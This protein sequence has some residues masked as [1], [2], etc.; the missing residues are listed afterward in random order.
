ML[1][2][3]RVELERRQVDWRTPEGYKELQRLLRFINLRV[4]RGAAKSSLGTHAGL[5][6]HG[7]RNPNETIA[8]MSVNDDGASAFCRQIRETME[9]DLYRLFFP[10][11]IPEGNLAILWTEKR[12]FFGGRTISHPQWT[13][14]ARG[15]TSSWART[16]FNRFFTDDLVTD[17]NCNA[18]DL[19][20]MRSNLGNMLGL[21]MPKVPIWRHHLGTVW[22]P[23]DDHD[24]LRQIDSC[25][26]IVVPIEIYP[27][28]YPDSIFE[29]RGIP[30]NPE[31]HDE[32]KIQAIVDASKSTA[33]EYKRNFWLDPHAGVGD[34]IFPP[35]L[36][37]KRKYKK[38]M[39]QGKQKVQRSKLNDKKELVDAPF[40]P[41]T[42]MFRVVAIDP[43]F[44]SEATADEWAITVLGCD[45]DGV[46]YQLKTVK[47]RGWENLKSHMKIEIEGWDPDLIGYERAGA[48]E[49]NF[50]T[51]L[52]Y[53]SFFR[54]W[55]SRFVAVTHE[56]L[57]K[58]IR[59][60]NQVREPLLAGHLYLAP[61][62]KAMFREL[63]DYIPGPKA[64]DNGI[65][66]IA[67]GMSLMR[68]GK[69]RG[70]WQSK[71]KNRQRKIQAK[72]TR[73]GSGAYN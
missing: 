50:K 6:W 45:H 14:E 56:N 47:G 70:D 42:D 33:L 20:K 52:E 61:D 26:S 66:S 27:D 53:D 41:W 71:L 30:T 34:R 3:L 55:E 49:Q 21:Y 10:E 68:R 64:K 7:T 58:E 22:D 4:Y 40:S 46:S 17:G 1:A 28:G 51:L 57:K 18:A 8:L 11:R 38:V 35:S 73:Y 59:I 62:D 29:R 67:I 44:S 65:D 48:Q 36:I 12:L 54:R 9:S 72:R 23:E 69:N 32:E 13:V 19:A 39:H 31:W 24:V 25:L 5:L 16:H 15:F 37:E 43:A 63:V 2:A 60:I